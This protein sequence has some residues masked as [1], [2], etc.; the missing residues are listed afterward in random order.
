MNLTD[1]DNNSVQLLPLLI[2]SLDL[3]DFELRA[4]VINTLSL[5]V[6]EIPMELDTSISSM[7]IKVLRGALNDAA[8]TRIKGAV[9]SCPTRSR[10]VSIAPVR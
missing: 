10:I 1:K 3:P 7:A 5:L 2:S 6:K 9:V 8:S 4:N